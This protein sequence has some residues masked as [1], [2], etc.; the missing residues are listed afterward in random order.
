MSGGERT[1]TADFYVANVALYQ[2]SYTPV[3]AHR[4]APGRDLRFSWTVAPYWAARSSNI[5]TGRSHVPGVIGQ[6]E[7][8]RLSDSFTDAPVGSTVSRFSPIPKARLGTDTP[9]TESEPL[10]PFL[11]PTFQA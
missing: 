10:C 8:T 5:L 4:I 2:L 11:G 7:P 9:I 3:G 6:N 1:R